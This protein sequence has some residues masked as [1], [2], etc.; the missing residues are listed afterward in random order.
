MRNSTIAASVLTVATMLSATWI[1][2]A[3]QTQD[4]AQAKDKLTGFVSL[5][6]AAVPEFEGSDYYT[7]V[8]APAASIRYNGYGVS[9]RGLAAS[10]DIIPFVGWSAG[11]VIKYRG[12]RDDLEDDAVDALPSVD[13]SVELGG[14]VGYSHNLGFLPGD[15]INARAQVLFDVGDAHEGYFIDLSAGYGAMATRRLRLSGRVGMSIA[16]D[17][18]MDTYFSVDPAGSAAS[19]LGVFDAGGGVKDVNIGLSANYSITRNWGLNA[20]ATYTRLVGDAGD[21]TI[22]EDA[23]APDQ[24]F[25]NIGASYRF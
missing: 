1:P 17:E 20:G 15:A 14:F 19:G 2:L 8:P 11:P 7:P 6:V 3:A 10:L 23:G 13:A 25:G 16:D 9:L 22:V 12:E 21:S 5:G 24:F 4:P 18:Y